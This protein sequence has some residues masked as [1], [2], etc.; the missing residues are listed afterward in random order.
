M[1]DLCYGLG[2]D[3]TVPLPTRRA[4]AYHSDAL[5]AARESL[6]CRLGTVGL[7]GLRRP[8]KTANRHA[9][10]RRGLPPG[11]A[12]RRRI[13]GLGSPGRRLVP[14]PRSFRALLACAAG[15]H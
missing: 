11:G 8:P 13:D 1:P 3:Y 2:R 15:S 6:P 4:F 7:S 12:R 14:V 5:L 10:R 9:A